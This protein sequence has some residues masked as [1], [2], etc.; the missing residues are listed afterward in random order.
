MHLDFYRRNTRYAERLQNS[1]PREFQSLPRLGA[2][3][4]FHEKYRRALGQDLAAHASIL[5]VGCGVGQVVHALTALG[6]DAHGAEISAPNLDQARTGPGTFHLY[7]GEHLPFGNLTF[8]SVGAFNVLEH[9]ENPVPFLDEMARVLRPGGRLVVSSPNFRRMLGW[10]D[11]HPEMQG[12]AQKWRN[13]Q[14]LFH[15]RTAYARGEPVRF[16]TM[17]SIS[18]EPMQPDDDAVTATSALDLA[19][20]FRTRKFTDIRV[21]CVDRPIPRG[22]EV[23]LDA[24][25]LRYVML[26]SFVVATKPA[27]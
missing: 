26:N 7:D 1:D 24:T 21:S 14:K 27:R 20:Y 5:D 6:F 22:L 18:R 10:R 2:N 19:H 3:R 11:Y 25:P 17:K 12:L 9:V 8:D 23:L 16:D 4:P 13:A 15:R